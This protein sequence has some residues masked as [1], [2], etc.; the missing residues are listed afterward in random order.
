MGNLGPTFR[1]SKFP[2]LQGVSLT[3]TT[4]QFSKWDQSQQIFYDA[5]P[6]LCIAQKRH[7]NTL[8]YKQKILFYTVLCFQ[9]EEEKITLIRIHAQ[10]RVWSPPFVG[11]ISSSSQ[12]SYP[13]NRKIKQLLKLDRSSLKQEYCECDA[14]TD[15]TT[16]RLYY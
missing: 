10:T 14:F 6:K 13:A 15:M 8:Q 5:S 4:Q 7:L 1:L 11:K 9:R 12:I 16:R 2:S 3:L